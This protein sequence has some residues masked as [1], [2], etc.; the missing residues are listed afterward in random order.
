MAVSKFRIGV[1]YAMAATTTIL[2]LA[3][4]PHAEANLVSILKGDILAT[5]RTSLSGGG[6]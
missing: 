6:G 3:A 5:L 4:D 2:L 1:A